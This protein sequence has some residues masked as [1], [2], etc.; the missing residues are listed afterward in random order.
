MGQE[1]AKRRAPGSSF[2][3]NVWVLPQGGGA[4]GGS[5]WVVLVLPASTGA[6]SKKAHVGSSLAL[7]SLGFSDGFIR[8]LAAPPSCSW[9]DP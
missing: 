4:G 2:K 7:P 3:H 8:A 1:L 6:L 9:L 5:A